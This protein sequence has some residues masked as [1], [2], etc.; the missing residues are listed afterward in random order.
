MLSKNAAGTVT[1]FFA[2]RR[3]RPRWLPTLAML[4][5]VAVTVAAGQWQRGRALQKE[6]LAAQF[7][8]AAAE[9]P[10]DLVAADTEPVRLRYRSGR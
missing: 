1:S 10:A 9:P 8:A 2:T 6:A 4:G 5:V 7:A 3:F